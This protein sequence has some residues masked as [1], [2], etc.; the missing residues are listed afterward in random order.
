MNKKNKYI[1]RFSEYMR[2]TYINKC[3]AIALILIGIVS[4]YILNDG[5][6]LAFMMFFGLPLFFINDNYIY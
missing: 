6:F 2:K 1:E 4:M 3:F 5:T